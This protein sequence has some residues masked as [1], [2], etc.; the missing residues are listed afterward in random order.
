MKKNLSLDEITMYRNLIQELDQLKKEVPDDIPELLRRE[1][2]FS[3]DFAFFAARRAVLRREGRLVELK[4][5]APEL[6]ALIREFKFLWRKRS[7]S[8]GLKESAAKWRNIQKE[9]ETIF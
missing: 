6:N 1:M 3:A 8:G 5:L 9:L 7:R 2:I 4:K